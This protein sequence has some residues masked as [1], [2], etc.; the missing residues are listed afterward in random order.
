MAPE[1]ADDGLGE[2][3]RTADIT[4]WVPFCSKLLAGAPA[5]WSRKVRR[6]VYAVG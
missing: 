5:Q 3:G 2:I 6:A 4:R 1:Q